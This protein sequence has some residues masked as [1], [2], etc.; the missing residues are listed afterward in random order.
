MIKLWDNK[1][2]AGLDGV[3]WVQ[4]WINGEQKLTQGSEHTGDEQTFDPGSKRILALQV[5]FS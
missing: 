5:S 1:G 4:V 2:K 3:G